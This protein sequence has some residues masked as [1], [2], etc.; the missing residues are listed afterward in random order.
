MSNAAAAHVANFKDCL[1]EFLLFSGVH[2]LARARGISGIG[3][4]GD[5][6]SINHF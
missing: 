3:G 2:L 6:T 4:R 5:Q 1:I